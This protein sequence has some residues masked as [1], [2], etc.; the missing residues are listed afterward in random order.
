MKVKLPLIYSENYLADLGAHVFRTEKYRLLKE[1]I[2]EGGFNKKVEFFKPEYPSDEELLLVH[3]KEW[4]EKLKFGTLSLEELLRLELPYSDE[5]LKMALLSVGGTILSCRLA[6]QNKVS[7]HIGGGF[8][9][10]Y[11]DYGEGFCA[12]NDIAVGIRVLQ[13]EKLIKKAM[14]VDCDLHQGNGTAR[15][16]YGDPTVFTFSI[17]QE[18]NYPVP[19]EK[20]S[21]DIGLYSGAGDEEYL[22]ALRESFPKFYYNQRPELVVYVAGADPYERDQ[23][24]GLKLTKEGLKERDRVV[25]EEAYKMRIPIV[26]LLAGGYAY[27]VNET[28]EIHFNTFLQALEVFEKWE[29]EN[30]K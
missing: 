5:L 6:L 26:I 3:R 17:H 15:I 30:S 23:L 7:Y 20:S 14:I 1:K 24:G 25:I 8:H 27:D 13:K 28:V 21:V 22:K 18:D 11:P 4:I 12:L 10:A 19:K 2:L 16:F 9:H 29:K